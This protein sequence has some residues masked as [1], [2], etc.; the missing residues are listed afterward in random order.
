MTKKVPS[1]GKLASAPKGP[2]AFGDFE[3]VKLY[4]DNRFRISETIN[5]T[6]GM[7]IDEDNCAGYYENDTLQA[8]PASTI[9]L[10][11]SES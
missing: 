7:T 5:D 11:V 3:P 4:D 6:S 9:Q 2:G 1:A 10:W 8:L